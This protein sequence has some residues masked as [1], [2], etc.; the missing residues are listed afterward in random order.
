MS[1]FARIYHMHFLC[2]R[3]MIVV[4]RG[5]QDILRV[6]SDSLVEGPPEDSAE[7]DHRNLADLGFY[8]LV[9][10]L[11]LRAGGDPIPSLFSS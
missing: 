2:L 8:L 6:G 9:F 1:M 5:C 7:E 11:S 3:M 4:V 10:C